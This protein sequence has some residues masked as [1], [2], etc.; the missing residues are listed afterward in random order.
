MRRILFTACIAL[1]L[2]GMQQRIVVH[3]VDHLRAK[4][5]RGSETALQQ[6]FDG[7]CIECTLL[8]AAK[9][10]FAVGEPVQH[11]APTYAE[12]TP[13]VFASE[14]PSSAPVFYSSRAPPHAL[15]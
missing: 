1:L 2:L 12:Q 7:L 3:E 13:D 8:S 14:A 9:T 5:Q 4:V 10:G 6:S 11:A 15:L